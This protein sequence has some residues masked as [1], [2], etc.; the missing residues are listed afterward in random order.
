MIISEKTR[1]NNCWTVIFA[2][3]DGSHR[4]A[5][6][7]RKTGI[8]PLF[9]EE[10]NLKEI[11]AVLEVGESRAVSYTAR[12]LNGYALNWVSYNSVNAAL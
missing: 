1:Y 11:G 9:Q 6:G 3:G 8:N 10:L 7:A 12:P 2:S 4:N 5:A